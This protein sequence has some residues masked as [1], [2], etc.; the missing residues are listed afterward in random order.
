[1][2]AVSP[3]P[4]R[5]LVPLQPLPPVWASRSPPVLSAQVWEPYLFLGSRL[6]AIG[7]VLAQFEGA[8]HGTQAQASRDAAL[9]G[10]AE[11]WRGPAA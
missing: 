9:R 4:R 7:Q 8:G 1:M 6:P 2:R 10:D 5:D 3:T 11:G